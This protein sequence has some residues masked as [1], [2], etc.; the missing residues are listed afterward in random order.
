MNVRMR[1]L[2]AE[3]LRW[4]RCEAQACL[5]ALLARLVAFAPA[6]CALLPFLF[7]LANF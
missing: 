7:F 5:R 6:C 1:W 2:I 3:S 4:R